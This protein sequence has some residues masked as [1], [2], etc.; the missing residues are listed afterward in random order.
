MLK[1]LLL[2][3]CCFSILTLVACGYEGDIPVATEGSYT[4]TNSSEH[5]TIEIATEED[6]EEFLASAGREDGWLNFDFTKS[7]IG[8][9]GVVDLLITF[10][11]PISFLSL[12]NV[13]FSGG[14][15]GH[16]PGTRLIVTN[17]PLEFTTEID[18]NVAF[19]GRYLQSF[20]V[21]ADG[22]VELD[23]LHVFPPMGEWP[24][25]FQIDVISDDELAELT[26]Y[27]HFDYNELQGFDAGGSSNLL[28]TFNQTIYD[29]NLRDSES[30]YYEGRGWVIFSEDLLA[31]DSLGPELSLVVSNFPITELSTLGFRVAD[32][33]FRG[34]AFEH[35]CPNVVR[36]IIVDSYGILDG[37]YGMCDYDLGDIEIDLG[38][39]YGMPMLD[40]INDMEIVGIWRSHVYDHWSGPYY[41]YWEFLADGSFFEWSVTENNVFEHW[42]GTE[43]WST[44]DDEMIRIRPAGAPPGETNRFSYG[45]DIYTYFI[46]NNILTITQRASYGIIIDGDTKVLEPFHLNVSDA[47]PALILQN[48]QFIRID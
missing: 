17:F 42:F 6:M 40:P 32:Y 41:L 20:M 27:L 25:Y 24:E 44:L 46:E 26:G 45:K 4:D 11:E 16:P 29:F 5:I 9:T 15:Y 31:I 19:G 12:P 18:Y 14:R 1:K 22:E 23:L 38:G 7:L 37:T 2:A 13:G 21:N 8:E 28:F 33:Y 30:G 39:D 3:I 43:T 10:N 48:R 35:P 34:V 36:M 47:S